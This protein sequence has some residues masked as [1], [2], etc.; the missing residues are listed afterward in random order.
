MDSLDPVALA[1]AAAAQLRGSDPTASAWVSASAGSGK[2]KVLRDRV[3]RLLLDGVAPAQILCLTYTKAAAAEMSNRIAQTL[4]AWAALDDDRLRGELRKLAEGSDI[5]ALMPVARRLFARVLDTPGGMKIETI[6]AFCQ[7]LLRRFPLEAN[8]APHFELIEERDAAVLL[9]EAR[10]D[11]LNAARTEPGGDLRRALDIAVGR[12]SEGRLNDL[13]GELLNRRARFQRLIERSADNAAIGRAIRGRLRLAPEETSESILSA[14][15]AESACDPGT[16]RRI[17]EALGHGTEKNQAVAETLNAWLAADP[18]ARVARFEAYCGIFLTAEGEPRKKPATK[19]ALAFWPDANEAMAREAARLIEVTDRLR[20]LEIATGTEALLQLG[21]A[22]LERYENRKDAAA[23]LDYEDLILKSVDLL[24]RQGIAPWVLYKLDGGLDH[25]LIDEAQDTN[26]EQWQ[27]I[28]ALTA[29]F[30]AGQGAGELPRTLFA[31]GDRKQSIYSFQG[32]APEEFARYER[33]YLALTEGRL[34]SVALNVSFRSTAP[35][36]G[37]VDRV[38]N[39]TARP[40]V[41]GAAETLAHRVSRAGEFGEVV[42]WPLACPVDE[43]LPAPWSPPVPRE[44]VAAP[45]A[46]LAEAIAAQIAQLLQSG[47]TAQSGRPRR[48]HA[49]DIMILVRYR[50][51]FVELMVRALK[52][53]GIPVAGIDRMQLLEQIA[54]QDIIAF[55]EFLLL[56][57]DDLN[58][59]ALLKSPLV[60]VSEEELFALCVDRGGQSLWSR[61]LALAPDLPAAAQARDLLQPYLDLIGFATPFEVLARLLDGDGGRGRLYRRLGEECG[62]AIDE[63]LNLALAFEAHHAPDLQAMLNWMRQGELMVKRDLEQSAGRVRI[64]TVHGAKG[65]EA[66][67]VFLADQ[68]RAE[69]AATGL[70]WL[71]LGET[72]L[73]LWSP[74]KK[75]DD[76]VAADARAAAMERQRAEENRLLYVAMTRAEERL[77]V[78]GWQGSRETGAA[79]WH[80]HVLAAL[81]GMPGVRKVQR[82]HW[83]G[84]PAEG[85]KGD[86]LHLA[87][88]EPAVPPALQAVA[89]PVDLPPPAWLGTAA[90]AL[91]DPPRPLTPSRPSEP[92]PAALSPLGEDEGWRYQRGRVVHHLLELL[93]DLPPDARLDAAR[94]YLARPGSA[95]PP[96]QQAAMAAEVVAVIERPDF[97]TIFGPASRAEVPIVAT[98]RQADGRTRVLSGQIDRLVVLE[99]EIWVVDF[100]SNR[101]APMQP[102]QVSQ[103]YLAQLAAYRRALSSLYGEKEIRCFLL[104]T[105]GPRLME[106]PSAMLAAHGTNPAP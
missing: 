66:P 79:S 13:L 75:A 94:A 77:Y 76:H 62:E 40:G 43:E 19:A 32:A 73:P 10:D 52:R 58:L 86:A 28:A 51:G 96:E 87:F 71:E 8:V 56:P 88:G 30:F 14:A 26:P 85:W 89:A 60:G 45:E 64:M 82:P 17:A 21:R 18:A 6:H 48:L 34:R 3:L 44:L 68:R 22:V 29:E 106:L 39:G 102:T 103:Q 33:H 35:V 47:T 20:A 16:L 72:E 105:D 57:E 55:A 54:V 50:T 92:D 12:M 101:P 37:L 90:P 104:W 99:S 63:F 74:N 61:V 83:L 80:D 4:A 95:V 42:L 11:M 31:V 67:V 38:F 15:V 49:G 5:R 93:P 98:L 69:K 2:T 53:R 78:C 46:R 1:E 91:P 81:D 7:S 36:L 25:V 41:Q 59:A 84:G 97:A 24:R 70:F 23:R 65:L 9:R 100:K 27:V